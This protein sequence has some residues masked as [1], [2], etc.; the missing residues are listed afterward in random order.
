MLKVVLNLIPIFVIVLLALPTALFLNMLDWTRDRGDRLSWRLLRA[1]VDRPTKRRSQ[2]IALKDLG[3]AKRI[4]MDK[5][6]TTI[7]KGAGKKLAIEGRIKQI[8][9]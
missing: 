5:D 2:N 9:D 6:N 8:R 4:I 3:R 7:V 1:R